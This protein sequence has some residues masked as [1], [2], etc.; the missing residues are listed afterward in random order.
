MNCLNQIAL[1]GRCKAWY[2][3]NKTEFSQDDLIIFCTKFADE[4]EISATCEF[5]V[6]D[7]QPITEFENCLNLTLISDVC[8]TYWVSNYTNH[9]VAEK[10]TFCTKWKDQ[11]S[12]KG[13]CNLLPRFNFEYC[14][15]FD[16]EELPQACITFWLSG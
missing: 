12:I 11:P 2:A 15:D 13:I 16:E 14:L 6:V 1:S 5:N 7:E 10:M 4:P 9:N 8:V 3:S